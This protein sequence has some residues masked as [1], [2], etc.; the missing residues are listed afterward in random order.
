MA[1]GSFTILH[2]LIRT[3]SVEDHLQIMTEM[4][5][6]SYQANKF[7]FVWDRGP[8]TTWARAGCLETLGFFSKD[9]PDVL[10]PMAIRHLQLWCLET[11]ISL[12]LAPHYI[13]LTKAQT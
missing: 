4:P 13:P 9:D 10:G 6:T 5:E 1:D 7:E 3:I 11:D 2:K 8:S 12:E